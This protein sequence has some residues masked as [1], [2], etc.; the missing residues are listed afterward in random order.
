MELNVTAYDNYNR[1]F[2]IDQYKFM[3]F[4]TEIESIGIKK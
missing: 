1:E 4:S 3:E 2:D